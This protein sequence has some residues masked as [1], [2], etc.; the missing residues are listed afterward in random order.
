[1]QNLKKERN[2]MRPAG[3]I[4]VLGSPN[5]EKGELYTTA[6]NRCLRA[7]KEYH[8]RS[9]WKLL[10][11]GGYGEHFNTTNQ[12]HAEYLNQFLTD[13]SVPE[14][15]I[16]EYAESKNTIQDALLSKPIVQKYQ[17]RR[18]LI[19]TSDYHLDR[20]KYIFERVFSNLDVE[21]EFIDVPTDPEI[22]E[23]DLKSQIEHEKRSL[24]AL[25]KAERRR[26]DL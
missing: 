1:M 9:G 26:I 15:D 12:P 24:L 8:Q 20:A 2:F 22:C 3:M 7:I 23:F 14:S 13:N 25:K 21:L 5:S 17:T 10:L 18:L 19:I 6:R 11:T 16:V 4:V